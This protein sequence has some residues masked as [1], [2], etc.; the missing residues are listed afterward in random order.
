MR[1]LRD[2]EYVADCEWRLT[3]SGLGIARLLLGGSDS[4]WL[5]V[6]THNRLDD[7]R[8]GYAPIRGRRRWVVVTHNQSTVSVGEE[9][10][11]T[12]QGKMVQWRS[13]RERWCMERGALSGGTD[14]DAGLYTGVCDF[15]YNGWFD[16]QRGGHR[17]RSRSS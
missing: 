2:Q 9:D 12:V 3:I 7:G 16:R 14:T 5:W 6:G 11:K 10:R 13:S 1:G 4:C 17:I 15:V 8:K